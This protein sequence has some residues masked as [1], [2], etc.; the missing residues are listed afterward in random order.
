MATV[1]N[2][3]FLGEEFND[4]RIVENTITTLP[5]NYESKNSS[6]ED[7]M[8]LSTISLSEL[9]NGLHTQEQ[10]S[11]NRLEEHPKGAFQAKSKEGSSSSYKGK[12]PWSKKKRPKRDAG[13]KKFQLCIHC[14]KS[15]DLE[16]C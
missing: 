9:I 4:R 5:K 6:L 11:V 8:D 2:I 7:L 16:R 15:I 12:K 10:K 1:N 14:K 3:I 13:K